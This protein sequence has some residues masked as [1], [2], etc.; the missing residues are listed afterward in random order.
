MAVRATCLQGVCGQR[1]SFAFAS[2]GPVINTGSAPA[3]IVPG[4]RGLKARATRG[5]VTSRIPAPKVGCRRRNRQEPVCRLK[6]SARYQTPG[7]ASRSVPST[8]R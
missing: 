3:H 7:A 1:M 5:L 8:Q 2:R 6:D 4:M